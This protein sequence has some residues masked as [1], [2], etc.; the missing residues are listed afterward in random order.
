MDY[1]IKWNKIVDEYNDLIAQNFPN[2]NTV[3]VSPESPASHSDGAAED[4][5]ADDI[6]LPVTQGEG[7]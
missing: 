1:Y 5:L 7:V 6:S 2:V 4:A 3:E